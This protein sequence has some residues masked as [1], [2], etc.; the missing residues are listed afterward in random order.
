MGLGSGFEHPAAL[1]LRFEAPHGETLEEIK[2]MIE[3]KVQ[4]ALSASRMSIRLE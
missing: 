4:S 2:R 3:E 1:V